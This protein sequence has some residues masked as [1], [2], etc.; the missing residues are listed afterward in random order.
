MATQ[1]VRYPLPVLG[2]GSFP[3][4]APAGTAGA[5]SYSFAAAPTYGFFQSAPTQID[6]SISGTTRYTF[7]G[8]SFAVLQA[9]NQLVLGSTANTVT[10]TSPAPAA[11]RVYT[12]PDAGGAAS[13]V[14]TAG[15][16]TIAGVQTFSGQLIGKGTATNDSAAAGN[17]GEY[18]ESLIT[19]ATNYPATSV[20]GDA[21]SI[22]LTAGDWDVTLVFESQLNTGT[23]FTVTYFGISQTTGNSSTGLSDGVNRYQITPP[24]ALNSSGGSISNYRQSLSGTTTIYAKLLGIYTGGNPQFKCRLSARRMR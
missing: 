15:N 22:S 14:M 5:P 3:L 6:V 23:A 18:V 11:A 9:T 24:T 12:I 16:Q 1:Y 2:S 10:I 19:T 21:T 17:I 8:S 4:L 13:F 7:G 20:I